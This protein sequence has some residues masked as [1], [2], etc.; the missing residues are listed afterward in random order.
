MLGPLLSLISAAFFGAQH[1]V[2]RRGLIR[3]EVFTAVFIAVVLAVPMFGLMVVV[4]GELPILFNAS[5]WALILLGSS[6]VIHFIIGRGFIY[7]SIKLIGSNRA[8]SLVATSTIITVLLAIGILGEPATIGVI[9]GAVLIVAGIVLVSDSGQSESRQTGLDPRDLR[10]GVA[11]AMLAAFIFGITPLLVRVGLLE[12]GSAVVGTLISY[13][14]AA[15]VYLIPTV[16]R[17]VRGEIRLTDRASMMALI[18]AGVFVNLGQLLRYVALAIIPAS[19]AT[20]I[21]NVYP[22]FTLT[23]GFVANRKIDIFNLRIALGVVVI[24]AGIN[25]VYFA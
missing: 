25:I 19:V 14:F 23:L 13:V 9:L 8:S 15:V 11:I 6:G 5:A 3:G 16:V 17:R 21:I 20:P 7:W 4:T 10:K 18:A 22:L 1:V 24:V 2:S 12:L